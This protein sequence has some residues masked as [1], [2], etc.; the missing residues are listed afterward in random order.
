MI[1]RVIS[2]HIFADCSPQVGLGHLRRCLTLAERLKAAGMASTFFTPDA[3]GKALVES[4]SFP[5]FICNPKSPNIPG[6]DLLII[7]GYNISLAWMQ[8]CKSRFHCRLII[9]D[10]AD[11]PL[12]GEFVF[13]PHI[14]GDQL[15]YQKVF[16]GKVLCGLHDHLVHPR[17]FSITK[18]HRSH[19]SILISF[20]GSDNGRYAFPVARAILQR[21]KKAKVVVVISPLWESNTMDQSDPEIFSQITLVHGADMAEMLKK[22]DVYLCG[23]GG[24]TLEGWAAGVDTISAVLVDNQ[25]LNGEA[26]QRMNL[27]VISPWCAERLAEYA[28]NHHQKNRPTPQL[29]KDGTKNV[30]KALKRYFKDTYKA[31]M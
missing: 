18:T 8:S 4:L 2:V 26:M 19:R 7:D 22:A 9:D 29:K 20:G 27:P 12:S 21:D 14:Y 13:N 15:D 31:A 5:A 10:L 23:A 24:S 25:R 3:T 11:R 30:V 16:S 17:F 6:A 28:L 1:D